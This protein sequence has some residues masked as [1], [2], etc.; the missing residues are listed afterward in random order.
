ELAVAG[1]TVTPGYDDSEQTAEAFGRHGLHTGD[2]GFV[3]DDGRLHVLDRRS[4]RIVTG[5]ENVHPGEVV[6]VLRDHPA[7]EDAAV[8]GIDDPEW[9][10]RVAALVVVDG[11]ISADDL[12]AHCRNRIADYKRPRTVAFAD[13]IP[14]TASD[15]VDREA[16]HERLSDAA[17]R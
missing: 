6:D 15:T 16:V 5:G 13:S 11:D 1:P 3:D 14:R 17:G 9:G 8:V 2:V 4:D 10:E 12:R 7:V